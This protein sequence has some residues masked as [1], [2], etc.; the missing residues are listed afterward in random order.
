MIGNAA[1]AVPPFPW[2]HL[3]ICCAVFATCIAFMAWDANRDR[4]SAPKRGRR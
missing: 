4:A 3:A 1:Q 2:W